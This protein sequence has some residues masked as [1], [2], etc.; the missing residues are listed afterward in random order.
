M[1][2]AVFLEAKPAF[3]GR[4]DFS[5]GDADASP[6][7]INPARKQSRPGD[8]GQQ[9]RVH[10]WVVLRT[11]K[12]DKQRAAADHGLGVADA[13]VLRGFQGELKGVVVKGVGILVP[14]QITLG[15]RAGAAAVHAIGG[16]D[17]ARP[18]NSARGQG[19]RPLRGAG[20]EEIATAFPG[21]QDRLGEGCAVV[22]RT[23]D[24]QFVARQRRIQRERHHDAVEER[25]LVCR[26]GNLRQRERLAGEGCGR[27]AA[28]PA[29]AVQDFRPV[30]LVRGLVDDQGVV[31]VFR[32][33]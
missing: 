25:G 33:S 29:F 1:N 9:L 27:K 12:V 13:P 19:A 14:A 32:P 21:R 24:Q 4:I 2:G 22:F 26:C 15:H 5:K 6:F 17:G 31:K 10:G 18:E 23:L 8:L 11:A 7:R 16:A 30:C 28:E 3:A 20:C